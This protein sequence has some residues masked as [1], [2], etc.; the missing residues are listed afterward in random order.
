MKLISVLNC[1]ISYSRALLNLSSSERC[2]LDITRTI[3][4]RNQTYSESAT[5]EHISKTSLNKGQLLMKL[6]VF[7]ETDI[8]GKEKQITHFVPR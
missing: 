4:L 3:F 5:S 2:T 6:L 7:W 8:N 1:F